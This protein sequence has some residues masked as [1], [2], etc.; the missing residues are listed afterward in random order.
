LHPTLASEH[1]IIKVRGFW[2]VIYLALAWS[3]EFGRWAAS[4]Y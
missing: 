3:A 1:F 4:I 2:Y